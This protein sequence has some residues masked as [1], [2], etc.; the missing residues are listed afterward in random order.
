MYHCMNIV[1]HAVDEKVHR[2]LARW[3]ATS[4]NR[5][6]VVIDND[7]VVGLQVGLT[8]AGGRGQN[9]ARIHAHGEVAIR[10]RDE[11]RRMQTMSVAHN[12]FPKFAFVDHG[13]DLYWC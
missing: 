1:A 4:G 11:A 12:L 7:Q 8:H 13:P 3:A 6:S 9:A 2:Q 10:S 5:V